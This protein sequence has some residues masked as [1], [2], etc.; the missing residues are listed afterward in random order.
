MIHFP[1]YYY[2]KIIRDAHSSGRETVSSVMAG[3]TARLLGAVLLAALG[4]YAG[5]KGPAGMWVVDE[6][7]VVVADKFT[8]A[9]LLIE[10]P[11]GAVRAGIPISA[12][13]GS[14]SDDE[15]R[16]GAL[17]GVASCRECPF[18]YA[19]SLHALHRVEIG[20]P[21]ARI[22][23]D[24]AFE[25]L[26]SARLISMAAVLRGDGGGDEGSREKTAGCPYFK[27][28]HLS[29]P[30]AKLALVADPGRGVL[31][32][33]A[34]PR[35][36]AGATAGRDVAWRLELWTLVPSSALGRQPVA[37]VKL[38]PP[39][40][41]ED[42]AMA[43]ARLLVTTKSE[44]W[45]FTVRG[46][47][48]TVGAA[49]VV[50][51]GAALGVSRACGKG[52][53]SRFGWRDATWEDAAGG[54][55]RLLAV[56]KLRT[57]KAGGPSETHAEATRN[58]A[59]SQAD[60][61]A[62]SLGADSRR[63]GRPSQ[64]Q[65]DEDDATNET[66][67]E[68]TN[69]MAVFELWTSSAAST[70][71]DGRPGAAWE[72]NKNNGSASAPSVATRCVPLAGRA[73]GPIDWR[74]GAG[75][76]ARFSRPHGLALSARADALLLTDID[77][78]VLRAVD[79]GVATPARRG[80]VWTIAYADDGPTS[81]WLFDALHGNS[82]AAAPL[83]RERVVV[84]A[85][86][87]ERADESTAAATARGAAQRC[88]EAGANLCS[89]RA[90]RA[91]A[92][93][94]AAHAARSGLR[95][96]SVWL[97]Q[98]CRSCWLKRAGAECAPPTPAGS[99][100]GAVRAADGGQRALASGPASADRA[101]TSDRVGAWGSLHMLAVVGATATAG[102]ATASNDSSVT[103]P[104]LQLWCVPGL[105]E[106]DTPQADSI[107]RGRLSGRAGRL[108]TVC[109]DQGG[110][111]RPPSAVVVAAAQGHPAARLTDS[112]V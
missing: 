51:T 57:S 42:G 105:S 46:S 95:S 103:S 69:G 12:G 63:N 38:F 54:G 106:A 58:R 19:T 25:E 107:G 32:F 33:D 88:A 85:A 84:A 7:F 93:E 80:H 15:P 70:A 74:D 37:S 35:T 99:E 43:L 64:T 94:V 59:D 3:G 36:R 68:L 13:H 30:D 76:S 26:R 100:G 60:S 14:P 112:S 41:T 96:A 6:R 24:R 49:A 39:V 61:R 10:M 55:P 77:S 104:R 18:I 97:S 16:A 111:E 67:G 4:V 72:N 101:R 17:V 78:R 91:D 28:I 8:E 1:L 11:A 47:A 62:D 23:A 65:T 52:R 108:G 44:V 48:T 27:A 92:A 73:G 34:W 9:L 22:C 71:A 82:S 45:Q 87:T 20:R 53:S 81:R 40:A 90:L 31:T 50:G 66:D 2:G 110:P 109:C 86:R 75:P 56:G 21:L 89:L 29:Q 102:A 79:L 83:S 98:L 5:G